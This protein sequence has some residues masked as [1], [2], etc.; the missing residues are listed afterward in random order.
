P[1]RS[2]IKSPNGLNCTQLPARTPRISSKASEGLLLKRSTS[3]HAF[4]HQVANGCIRVGRTNSS[5][6]ESQ[7]RPIMFPA[8]GGSGSRLGERVFLS[9][10]VSRMARVSLRQLQWW[11]ERKVVSPR[12]EDHRRAYLPEQVLESLTVAALRQK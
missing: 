8:K 12:K 9:A 3:M 1:G 5:P 7:R 11:D 4:S 10:D 2:G 6:I